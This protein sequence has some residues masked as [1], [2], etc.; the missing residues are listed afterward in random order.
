MSHTEGNDIRY[1]NSTDDC[2]CRGCVPPTRFPGCHAVCIQY[3]DWDAKR[4][5][6]K[7]YIRERRLKEGEKRAYVKA[8]YEKQMRRKGW[9]KNG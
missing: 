5:A 1:S 9:K 4:K 3:I 8:T 7:Q 6:E 2:P